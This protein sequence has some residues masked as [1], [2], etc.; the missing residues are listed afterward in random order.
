M[1]STCSFIHDSSACRAIRC[2]VADSLSVGHSFK[3]PP[4]A[5]APPLA[6]AIKLAIENCP[7]R[8]PRARAKSAQCARRRPEPVQS[9]T[10]ARPTQV[11]ARR[12]GAA[13]WDPSARLRLRVLLVPR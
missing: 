3:P 2:C 8:E 9:R 10:P 12:G 6:Q 13:P 4:P 1:W 5:L 11:I 7:V